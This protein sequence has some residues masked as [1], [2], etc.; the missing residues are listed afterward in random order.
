MLERRTFLSGLAAL[1]LTSVAVVTAAAAA[2]GD[3]RL[4]IMAD[5]LDALQAHA[6]KHA[7]EAGWDPEDPYTLAIAEIDLVAAG[8]A[9]LPADT[10]AGVLL[11]LRGMAVPIVADDDE[12]HDLALSV[13]R[14]LNRLRSI[15]GGVHV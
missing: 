4:G 12:A 5:R 8:M 11:K 2:S 9:S 13:C 6:D 1:P 3:R 10:M 14:D 7:A 15:Q